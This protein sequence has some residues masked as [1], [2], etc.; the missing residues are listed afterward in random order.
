MLIYQLSSSQTDE[1]YVGKT[2]VTLND[3]LSKH[4]SDYK[5][6]ANGYYIY[7]SS[8]KIMKYDDHKIEFIEETNNSLREIYW[9]QKLNC[10]NSDYNTP[11]LHLIY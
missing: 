6:W 11:K 5:R 7:K 2:N 1:V 8:Y 9:I 10:C 3:R 4:R